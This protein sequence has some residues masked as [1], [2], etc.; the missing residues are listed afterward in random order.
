MLTIK[1]SRQRWVADLRV[2]RAPDNGIIGGLRSC[3]VY[4]VHS[5]VVAQVLALLTPSIHKGQVACIHKWLESLPATTGQ[6]MLV[7][8]AFDTVACASTLTVGSGVVVIISSIIMAITVSV[9]FVIHIPTNVTVVAAVADINCASTVVTSTD[10]V[11]V[12]NESESV[13]S[14]VLIHVKLL[15]LLL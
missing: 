10:R 15:F 5:R 6:S 9:I 2:A 4:A 11:V 8:S 7:E 3:Q 12:G 14:K 1:A 13:V